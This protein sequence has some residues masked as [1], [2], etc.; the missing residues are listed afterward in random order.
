MNFTEYLNS[1][2]QKL[3]CTQTELCNASKLSASVISRYLSGDR[4]PA[5]DSEQLKALAEGIH[6]IAVNKGLSSDEFDTAELI[7]AF[8]DAINQKA[9][10]YQVFAANFSDLI[11][12]FDINMKDI[13]SAL[14]FDVSY[15]YRVK[16]GERHPVDLV[17]FCDLVSEY[18]ATNKTRS[19]D[20][21]IASK[22][23]GCDEAVLLDT[24]TYQNL[25]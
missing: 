7:I 15:L 8:N 9:L 22:L 17:H 23:L 1:I 4:E 21:A 11:A 5:A 19:E 2:Y 18:I 20:I 10:A 14:N 6:E 13:A 12:A 3:N 24:N 16:S 25:T